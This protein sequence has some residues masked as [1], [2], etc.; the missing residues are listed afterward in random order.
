MPDP[1]PTNIS[2]LIDHLLILVQSSSVW[3]IG[4]DHLGSRAEECTENYMLPSI[5]KEVCQKSFG[6]DVPQTS[7][8]L[9]Q[10]IAFF[11]KMHRCKRSVVREKLTVQH[12][13]GV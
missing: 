10:S 6:N 2:R 8:I 11:N 9:K 4:G 1:I 3:S 13:D 7:D 12:G 5:E